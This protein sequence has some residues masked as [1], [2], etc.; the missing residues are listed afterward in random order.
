MSGNSSDV[1][2]IHGYDESTIIMVW[3]GHILSFPFSNGL[4]QILQI[5]SFGEFPVGNLRGIWQ[6]WMIK[7]YSLGRKPVTAN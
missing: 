3:V 7:Y 6:W 5:G 2:K 1:I 4:W